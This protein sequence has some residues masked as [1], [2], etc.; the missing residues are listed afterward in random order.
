MIWLYWYTCRVN[1]WSVYF[2]PKWQQETS[3]ISL[4]KFMCLKFVKICFINSTGILFYIPMLFNS[5]MFSCFI[6]YLHKRYKCIYISR[7][8][9]SMLITF[10]VLLLLWMYIDFIIFFYFMYMYKVYFC[11]QSIKSTLIGRSNVTIAITPALL[12]YKFIG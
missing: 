9:D 1:L 4:M 2:S 5:Q 8:P 7:I 10:F 12:T 3:C 6:Q 11:N